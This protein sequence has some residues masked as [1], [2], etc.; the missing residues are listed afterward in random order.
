M[1]PTKDPTTGLSKPRVDGICK[2]YMAGKPTREICATFEIGRDRLGR[3]LDHC[4]IVRRTRGFH[5]MQARNNGK[6]SLAEVFFGAKKLAPVS[7]DTE[8]ESAKLRLRQRGMIVYDATVTDGAKAK[9]WIKVDHIRMT[10]DEVIALA[11]RRYA[12]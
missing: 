8:L 1:K 3:I 4:K 9:G 2:A 11:N 6:R 12:A 7:D 5:I 10:R